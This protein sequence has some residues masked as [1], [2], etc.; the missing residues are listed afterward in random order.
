MYH[1]ALVPLPVLLLL[2]LQVAT[3][4][5]ALAG[6]EQEVARFEGTKAELLGQMNQIKQ[7]MQTDAASDKVFKQKIAEMEVQHT[8]ELE[9]LRAEHR[10]DL[11]RLDSDW[12]SEQA[13]ELHLLDTELARLRGERAEL[14]DRLEVA[15]RRPLLLQEGPS[16]PGC[17]RSRSRW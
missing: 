6:R 9:A 10:L 12:E 13:V 3:L 5:E 8:E 14:V 4:Q 15:E 2:L 1:Y 11:E 17:R 16:G 7:Q